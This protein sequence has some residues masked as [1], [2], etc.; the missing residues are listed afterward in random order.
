M[1]KSKFDTYLDESKFKEAVIMLKEELTKAEM[2]DPGEDHTWGPASDFLGYSIL[3]KDGHEAFAMYWEEILK[4]FSENL[5]P[6]WGHLH[7]G[8]IY[9]RLGFAKFGSELTEA[10]KYLEIG[11]TEDVMTLKKYHE[12]LETGL[13][14]EEAMAKSP[15][16][17]VLI[18]MDIL[19]NGCFSNNN[20]KLQ[21]FKGMVP[22]RWDVIWGPKEEDRDVVLKAVRDLTPFSEQERVLKVYN[23]LDAVYS[24]KLLAATR[25]LTGKLLEMMLFNILYYKHGI[26]NINGRDIMK[27]DLEDLTSEAVGSCIFPSEEI[28]TTCIM[29]NVLL[30][31]LLR[32]ED[33]VVRNKLIPR[34]ERAITIGLKILL[35]RALIQWAEKDIKRYI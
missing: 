10:R 4:F 31:R 26:K 12:D 11:N 29:V 18:V 20:E 23:D 34:V 15:N 25:N 1:N 9:M 30:N 3:K 27:A 13:P 35:D 24:L 8:H 17:I 7:K 5:E 28:R 2:M 32:V 22:I 21:F 16:H 6:V 19:E 33:Q 14:L